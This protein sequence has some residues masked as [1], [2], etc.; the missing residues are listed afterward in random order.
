V[1]SEAGKEST[2]TM[3]LPTVVEETVSTP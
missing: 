1:H 3:R 2:F